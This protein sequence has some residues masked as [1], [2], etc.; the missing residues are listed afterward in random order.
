MDLKK[1]PDQAS[2]ETVLAAFFAKLATK[3]PSLRHFNNQARFED[4]ISHHFTPGDTFETCHKGLSPLAFLPAKMF[5]NIHE[6]KVAEDYY[7][8]ATVKTVTDVRK[9]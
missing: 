4:I 8:E 1:Q 7:N 9:H 5:A 6:E 3:E 2:W